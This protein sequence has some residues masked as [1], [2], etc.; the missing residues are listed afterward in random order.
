MA[1]EVKS[2]HASCDFRI[3]AKKWSESAVANRVAK[4]V[5]PASAI[6]PFKRDGKWQLD[7]SNDW[8]MNRIDDEVYEVRYRYN[9]PT[10]SEVMD[11][12]GVF[13]TWVFR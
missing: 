10:M 12:L 3:N 5:S 4:M 11:A 6:E 1:T 2:S 9:E 8:W 7:G 13:C